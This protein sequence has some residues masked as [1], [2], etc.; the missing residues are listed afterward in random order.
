M[1]ATINFVDQSSGNELQKI[2]Q[3]TTIMGEE[4]E[5]ENCDICGSKFQWIRTPDGSREFYKKTFE[6]KMVC[7]RK[8]GIDVCTQLG[9]AYLFFIDYL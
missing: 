9:G 1:S 5:K 6:D 7:S 2:D 3:S 4:M 8:C